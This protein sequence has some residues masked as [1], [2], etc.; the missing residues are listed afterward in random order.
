[1]DLSTEFIMCSSYVM[2]RLKLRKYVISLLQGTNFAYDKGI[3]KYYFYFLL[4]WYRFGT[5]IL[6]GVVLVRYQVP[7][8]VPS[9]PDIRYGIII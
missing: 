9:P 1:M 6:N 4:V 5:V 7:V 3:Y 2:I 8:L